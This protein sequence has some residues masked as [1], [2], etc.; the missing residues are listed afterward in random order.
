MVLHYFS[1]SQLNKYNV[2][3]NLSGFVFLDKLNIVERSFTFNEPGVFNFFITIKRRKQNKYVL[4]LLVKILSEIIS[5]ANIPASIYITHLEREG[6]SIK[7][8]GQT[9]RALPLAIEKAL[10]QMTPHFEQGMITNISYLTQGMVEV[11]FI[12]YGNKDVISCMNTRTM[13]GLQ[14]GLISIPAQ[15]KDFILANVMLHNWDTNWSNFEIICSE[16]RYLEFQLV[17][18]LE[19]G[20]YTLISLF[21]NKQ[22]ITDALVDRG[23]LLKIPIQV[24]QVTLQPLIARNAPPGLGI[25]TH[26]LPVAMP[27]LQPKMAPVTTQAVPTPTLLTYK[28]LPMENES[29][30]QIYVSYVSDGPCLFSVQLK[31]MEEQLKRLMTE[32]N[33][34]ELQLLEEYPLPGTVCLAQSTEDGYICRAVVT[35]MVDGEYKVFYVDFGNTELL[36]FDKLYQI[37]FKYVIPKVMATRFALA[38]LESS[39]VSMEMKCK[40][41]E[42]VNNRPLFMRV[43]P[44]ATKSA[45]PLC[46]LWDETGAKA[47]DMIK[48]AAL[49]S[50]PEPAPL[51][52]GVNQDVKVS[53]VYSCNKF[54]VQLKSKENE[55]Q[56]LMAS[57]QQT[58]F[59]RPLFNAQDLK[60]GAPCCCIFPGDSMWYRG[61]IL[62][63]NGDSFNIKYVDFGNETVAAY[64]DIKVPLPEHVTAL[65]PQAIECCLNG[66]QNFEP[67]ETRDIL[68]EDRRSNAA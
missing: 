23:L 48:Q 30:H 26:Q 24:Q 51:N 14:T 29:E 61:E 42:F 31:R 1:L 22:N 65:R 33:C 9:D 55:L 20:P 43:K 3:D 27:A 15:A 47:L 56:Q 68:L 62:E 32:I 50:Y 4:D 34:M 7:V 67:D 5:M 25:N 53:Y 8:W 28:A 54:F 46:E 21:L 10:Q 59:S 44:A 17:P 11:L 66:Y 36:Q 57:L 60:I 6:S 37:P 13:S 38:G 18:I 63:I 12:D 64:N 19:I 45:L 16:L 58:C 35:S 41:K 49:L 52:R 39:T 2:G 40:F